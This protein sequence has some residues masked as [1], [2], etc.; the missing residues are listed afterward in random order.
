MVVMGDTLLMSRLR[1]TE[2]HE[3]TNTTTTRV[4]RTCKAG[5]AYLAL[6]YAIFRYSGCS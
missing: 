1:D 4:S 2:Y 6:N 5:S 3:N